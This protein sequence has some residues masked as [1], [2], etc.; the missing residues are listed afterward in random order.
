[1]INLTGGINT[2]KRVCLSKQQWVNI[3]HG[4]SYKKPIIFITLSIIFQVVEILAIKYYPYEKAALIDEK[5]NKWAY[6]KIDLADIIV[7]LK[8]AS[9]V[10]LISAIYF[11]LIQKGVLTWN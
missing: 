5:Y 6:L 2:T 9:V 1:M 3:C 11:L 10:C 8:S 4:V 7:F